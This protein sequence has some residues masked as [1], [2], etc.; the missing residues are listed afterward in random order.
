LHSRDLTITAHTEINLD[1]FSLLAS[2][3][4][5]RVN[6]CIAAVYHATARHAKTRCW[7]S[8]KPMEA[9]NLHCEVANSRA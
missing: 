5:Q 8:A 9:A 3:H 7:R 2:F 4:I 6:S 1:W